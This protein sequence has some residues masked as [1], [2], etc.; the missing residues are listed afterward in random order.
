M[1]TLVELIR[2]D[3]AALKVNKCFGFSTK[4]I[5]GVE[6]N[7]TVHTYVFIWITYTCELWVNTFVEKAANDTLMYSR[8]HCGFYLPWKMILNVMVKCSLETRWVDISKYSM[9][10]SCLVW[11]R[12]CRWCLAA[13]HTEMRWWK[14]LGEIRNHALGRRKELF[15]SLFTSPV[16]FF[17]LSGSQRLLCC[18]C[19]SLLQQTLDFHWHIKEFRWCVLSLY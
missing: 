9:Y 4:Y 8:Q 14:A 7:A 1:S 16:S 13:L 10:E 19:H 5:V 11:L 12:R 6:T 18:Y 2:K 3:W 15:S 17:K